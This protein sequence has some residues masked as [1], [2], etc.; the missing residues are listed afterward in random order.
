MERKNQEKKYEIDRK[1][2]IAAL[3][4]K[5]FIKQFI[6]NQDKRE[7]LLSLMQNITTTL[8]DNSITQVINDET[9]DKELLELQLGRD[10]ELQDCH[11]EERKYQVIK[12]IIMPT[13]QGYVQ[14]IIKDDKNSSDIKQEI[15]NF[16]K[17]I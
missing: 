11:D 10:K 9:N 2:F 17:K 4:Y 5:D 1:F 12:Q 13:L 14:R 6:E 8:P 15:L 7:S 16:M 3:F